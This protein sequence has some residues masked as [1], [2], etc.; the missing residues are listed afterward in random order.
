MRPDRPRLCDD[1]HELVPEILAEWQGITQEEPW[2]TLPEEH[3]FNSLPDFTHD[4]LDAALCRPDEME[5]HRR[6]LYAASEHGQTRREQGFPQEL[7]LTEFYLLREA[8]WRILQRHLPDDATGAVM[9]VDTALSTATRASLA[10]FHRQEL[11]RLGQWPAV[12]ERL[13]ETSPI[14][15]TDR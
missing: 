15:P 3:R 1:P 11:E 2:L 4:L 8:I 14:A 10:G 6:K 7:V 5:A 9:R 12:I 13:L